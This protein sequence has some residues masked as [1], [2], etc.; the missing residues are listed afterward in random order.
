MHTQ[1]SEVMT[2]DA[3]TVDKDASF[4]DIAEVLI[5]HEVSAVP[6]IN[7]D[8]HVIGVVS[9]ADLLHKEEFKQAYYGEEYHP[10]L[11]ARLCRRLSEKGD[12]Q[13]KSTGDTAAELMTTPAVTVEP[14]KSVVYAARLMARHGVKRLP[15]VDEQDRLLGIV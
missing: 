5:N 8:G 9:E 4:K 14:D 6:V 7:A 2:A 3:A 1:V 13:I 10:P 11:R 15:V 12:S